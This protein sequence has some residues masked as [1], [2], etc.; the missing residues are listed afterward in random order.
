[1][2]R[3]KKD[4]GVCVKWVFVSKHMATGDWDK[5]TNAIIMI[6]LKIDRLRKKLWNDSLLPTSKF[7]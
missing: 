4:S 2:F 5:V 3:V 7:M 1:M 6:N